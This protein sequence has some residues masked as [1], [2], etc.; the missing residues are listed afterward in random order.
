MTVDDVSAWHAKITLWVVATITHLE[1]LPAKT[2][3]VHGSLQ[4]RSEF[5]LSDPLR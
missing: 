3:S 2:S 4:F 5:P 1:I